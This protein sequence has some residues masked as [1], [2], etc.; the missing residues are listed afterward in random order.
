[1]A[2]LAAFWLLVTVTVELAT[3][4]V[5]V[6]L[7]PPMRTEPGGPL[8]LARLTPVALIES[9]ADATAGTMTITTMTAAKP[10]TSRPIRQK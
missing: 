6:L 5:P 2:A 10:Q 7:I 4:L 1:L 9:V 8:V 3:A